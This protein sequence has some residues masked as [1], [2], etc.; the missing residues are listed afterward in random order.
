[1]LKIVEIVIIHLSGGSYETASI[2]SIGKSIAYILCA[3]FVG[4]AEFCGFVFVL[5]GGL[6]CFVDFVQGD[7]A[8]QSNVFYI[9]GN[10]GTFC[11]GVFFKKRPTTGA[12]SNRQV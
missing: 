3:V 4:G 9:W 10:W 2:K 5:Y 6:C 1:L 7:E 8:S 11:V 12:N